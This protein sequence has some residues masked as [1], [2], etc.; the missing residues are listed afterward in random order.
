[1]SRTARRVLQRED[2]AHGAYIRGS[3]QCP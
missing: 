1:L 2:L 3:M